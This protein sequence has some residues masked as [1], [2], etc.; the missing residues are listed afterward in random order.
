MTETPTVYERR[1]DW[2]GKQTDFRHPVPPE[3][4]ADAKPDDWREV[5]LPL[6]LYLIHRPVVTPVN[7]KEAIPVLQTSDRK[8]CYS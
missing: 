8:W 2:P 4:K 7:R 6:I 1:D 5:C 3:P